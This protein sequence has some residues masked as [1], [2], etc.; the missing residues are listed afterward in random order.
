MNQIKLSPVLNVHLSR[1]D[2]PTVAPNIMY[3][4]IF[5]GPINMVRLE[6]GLEYGTGCN[7]VTALRNS[8]GIEVA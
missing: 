5:H 8:P 3:D 4:S 6:F 7:Y 2:L 1:E